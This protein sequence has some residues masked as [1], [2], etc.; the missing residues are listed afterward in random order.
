MCVEFVN[1]MYTFVYF[2]PNNTSTATVLSPSSTVAG[3]NCSGNRIHGNHS[4]LSAAGHM[5][6]IAGGLMDYS[7]SLDGNKPVINTP[8]Q[9]SSQIL[10]N[11][12]ETFCTVPGD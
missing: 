2:W 7:S 11:P 9:L 5:P 4:S 3:N 1:N 10:V 12:L 6:S 8:M